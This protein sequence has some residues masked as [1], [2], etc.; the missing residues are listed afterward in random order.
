M[1]SKKSKEIIADIAKK[2][3]L[4]P[5]EIT[6]I[7][8]HPY[9]FMLARIRDDKD[10]RGFHDQFLGHFSVTLNRVVSLFKKNKITYDQAD[11]YISE[12][13]DNKHKQHVINELHKQQELLAGQ[14]GSEDESSVT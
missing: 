7:V 1:E 2:H 14:E 3:S 10:W 9:K 11:M 12:K 4:H 5:D 6:S 13:T 8:R